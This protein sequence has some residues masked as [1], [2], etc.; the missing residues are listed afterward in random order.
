MKK[1][2][3]SALTR[4]TQMK[5]QPPLFNHSVWPLRS[6][7]DSINYLH[8]AVQ[9]GVGSDGHVSAAEVV[10]DGA[11]EPHDVQVVVLLGQTVCD[12]SWKAH[13]V[14][15]V[16]DVLLEAHY[17]VHLSNKIMIVKT[18]LQSVL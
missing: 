11:H 9:R 13:I 1:I 2:C 4:V 18:Q 15:V 3:I 17:C 12:P 6:G 8:D 10:V 5:R 7:H 16:V 14:H